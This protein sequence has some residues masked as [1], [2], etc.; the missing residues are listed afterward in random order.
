MSSDHD[1]ALTIAC[2]LCNANPGQPCTRTSVDT[3]NAPR[4]AARLANAARRAAAEQ[5]PEP[6]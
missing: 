2:P 3:N 6:A 1:L 5:E 4:H